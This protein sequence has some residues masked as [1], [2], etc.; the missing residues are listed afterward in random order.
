LHIFHLPLTLGA[1][2]IP[3]TLVTCYFLLVTAS[4][5]GADKKL[6]VMAGPG[7]KK[8]V[9]PYLM[10]RRQQSVSDAVRTG[11]YRL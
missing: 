9:E 8:P 11:P 6:S 1:S 5:F 10:I 2:G 4:A 3:G 7:L